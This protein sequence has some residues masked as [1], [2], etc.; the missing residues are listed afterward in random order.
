M[1]AAAPSGYVHAPVEDTRHREQLARWFAGPACVAC[2]EPAVAH[3]ARQMAGVTRLRDRARAARRCPW[4]AG[5]V[6]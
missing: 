6:R 2:G 1:A 3:A 4:M 5:T